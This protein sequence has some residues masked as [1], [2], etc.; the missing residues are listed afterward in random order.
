MPGSHMK[1]GD[2]KWVYI[3]G[4]ISALGA[5]VFGYD[6]TYY[7]GILDM[8][9]YKNHYGNHYDSDGKK[10]LATSF[11]SLTTSSIYIG[12]LLGALLAAPVNERWGRKKTFLLAACCVMAGGLAQVA[13]TH[14]EAVIV[15]GRILIGLGIG[16]FTVTSLLYIGEIAPVSIRGP[17]LLMYQ[18][19]QSISQLVASGITQGTEGVKSTLSY[20]LPMGGLLI[21]PLIILLFLP[22]VPESPV[23]YVRKGRREA[24]AKSLARI[25]QNKDG[26]DPTDDLNVLEAAN[27]FEEE[28]QQASSWSALLFDPVERR[29]LIWSSGGMFAQQICGI[30][31]FYNY[32]VVFAADIGM[33]DPYLVT[34]ITNILQVFA[35]AASVL[36]GNK[37]RRRTNLLVTTLTIQVA[38]LVIGGIGTQGTISQGSKYV[39]V[40]FSYVVIVAYNFGLGPLTYMTG[41][42]YAVG[43]NQNKIM[44]VSVV[45]LYF[46][47]WAVS[48]TAPYLYTTAGLGPM[49]GFVYAGTSFFSLAWV[50]FCVA[51]TKDRTRVEIAQFFTDGIPARKWRT[52]VFTDLPGYVA[53]DKAGLEAEDIQIEDVKA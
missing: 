44:S 41:R 14:Y 30:I 26:Y 48:F 36:T 13:D 25:H 28:Q 24:A 50:W 52:H 45:V 5:L 9:E 17:V 38:F 21:L 49:L 19:L 43:V 53:T 2:H 12:D 46:S 33:S 40:V 11:T 37:I 23:W 34:L 32:G 35:V 16:Q 10:A 51:E 39:I 47:V 22:F 42:E 31:F 20:K 18:F 4:M 1:F 8:Q 15:I 3:F 27:R 6:N 29:K 7:S